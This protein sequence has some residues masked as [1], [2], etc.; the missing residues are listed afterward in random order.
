M[1]ED[2][3]RVL[4]ASGFFM[5]LLFLRLE[6][7]R[8]GAAEDDEPGG[9]RRGLPTQLAWYLIGAGLLWA[10][11]EIHPAPHDVL[12]LLVGHRTDVILYGTFLALLGL[13]QAAAF[14]WFRYGYLRL[15]PGREYPVAAVNAIATA[16]I[17]EAT[18]RGALLGTLVAVGLPG[19]GAIL[20]ST[21]VFVIVTRAA[22]PGRHPYMLFLAFGIG[23]ACG[24]ATLATGG[25]GAAMIGHAVASFAVFICTGHAGHVPHVGQEP[26]EVEL[27]KQLPEGWQDA[28][29]P[30][31]AGRGA[32][33]RGFAQQIE[34]SGFISRADRLA[35]E[36]RQPN[37]LLV[38]ARS[39]SRTIADDIERRLR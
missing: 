8:F 31:V 11:Y 12:F 1:T 34:P 25:L 30:T 26:E 18:F 20:I 5:L 27:R 22:G 28:R 2:T 3:V 33:P 9:R 16:V 37:G 7:S 13:G 14:A 24:W 4:V 6:A 15:P 32:E 10:I 21:L 38:W 36:S 35:A 23:L 19:P 29:R 39:V 17:D